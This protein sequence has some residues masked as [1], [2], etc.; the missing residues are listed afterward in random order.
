VTIKENQAHSE[1]ALYQ[2]G[3]DQRVVRIVHRGDTQ[4][5]V[6][7]TH[8]T[9]EELHE[10]Q[11]LGRRMQARAT[12]SAFASLFR[13]VVWAFRKLATAHGRVRREVAA[14]RHLGALDD[15]LLQDI[16]IPRE[17]IPAAVAGLMDRPAAAQATPA[18]AVSPQPAAQPAACNDPQAK[19]DA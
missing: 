14:I 19:A 18:A 9:M 5:R 2:P 4:H 13:S 12:A 16:G 15:H 8:V 17:Q 1:F 11:L 10:Y 6:P 3:V 7:G